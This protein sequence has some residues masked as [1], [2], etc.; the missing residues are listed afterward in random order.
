MAKIAVIAGDGIGQ[1]VVPEG[2]RVLSA[3]D[4]AHGLGLELEHFDLG[5]DRYLRDGTTMPAE[6]MER[7]RNEFDAIFL[8]ALGDPRV[9]SNVHAK[10]ILLGSRF[11]LDLFINLRPVK[12]LDKKRCP[13]K[14]KGPKDIDMVVFRENTEGLYTGIGGQ[15]KRGTPDEVAIE[16]EM[17]TR[18]GVERI[19]RAAF[20]YAHQHGLPSVCMSDKSNAMRHGH[21]LWQRTFKEVAAEYPDIEAFHL[22]VDVL[23]MELVRVPERFDVIVTNNLFGDIVTDLG[24]QLQ[25][26]IGRAASGNLHPGQVSLFEPV[27][28]SAPDIA[29]KG[30]ANPIATHMSAGMMLTHLGH[31]ELEKQILA[32]VQKCLAAGEV[33]RE[34]GGDLHTSAVTDALLGHLGLA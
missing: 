22:F 26:G 25:G 15:F 7:F 13:L 2:L 27:H 10:E 20:A 30:L 12:L 14:K 8:G 16:A 11:K 3:L 33:T 1:E 18:K 34:L 28:G 5:A 23:C 4:E 24:A 31:P 21:D 19:I 9:P 6:L 17:N 29:G 32:G